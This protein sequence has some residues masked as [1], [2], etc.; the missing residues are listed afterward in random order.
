MFGHIAQMP[1]ILRLAGFHDAV[2][3]R[4]VPSQVTKNA[5]VWEAPDGSSV[6]AE[7]LPVGYGNG[8]ALPDDAKAL[9]RRTARQRGRGGRLPHRRPAVHER[10]GPPDAP[11]LARPGRGRGQRPAGRVRLRGDLAPPLPGRRRP[12]RAST[13]VQGELRSGFRANMLMGV[14]SN[15]VD[16]KRQGALAERELE[17]RAEPLAALFQA[18]A[19]YPERLL[20]LAWLEMVRNSAHDSICACSVDDVV[21]AVLHRYAEARAIAAGLA[22]RAVKAFARSLAEP[23]PTRAQP[24]A[25]GPLRRRRAGRPR[26]RPGPG[27]RAGAL[28]AVRAARIDGARRRHGAHGAGHAAGTARSTTTPGSTTCGSRTPTRASTSRSPSG[29][30]RSPTSPSPRP[31]RTSTPG[32]GPGPT[33]WS[34]WPWTSRRRG[35]SSPA[36]AR[37]RGTAGRPSSRRRWPTPSRSTEA[38]GVGRVCQRAGARSTID[39]RQ[40]D[41]RPRRHARLR[42]AGRRRRPRRLV[43]LLAAPAGL[44]RRHAASRHRPGRRAGPGAG[45]GAHHQHLRLARPRRRL[46][47]GAG[48]RAPGRRR[49]RRGAAGGRATWCG[50]RPRSSTR[51]ATTA[52]ASTCRSPSRRSHSHAESAFTVVTRGLTAEGRPDEFGLPTAPVQPLRHGRAPD[53]GP[54]GRVRVRAVDVEGDAARTMALTVLRSTGMLSRL[55][56]AYR[57]FPAGPL[58]PVEGLQMRGKRVELRYALAL[59]CDD[60]YAAGRRRPAPARDRPEPGRRPAARLGQ[61]AGGARRRGQRA[62]PGGRRARGARLQPDGPAR[63]WSRSPVA[64]GWLVDLRGYPQE[65]FEGS[66]ELRPFGIATARLRDD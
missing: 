30:R 54:R 4:G 41:L 12:P 6:R 61:R 43:Q 24:V 10:V 35:R 57:P 33:P 53:R 50:S 39:P 20:E 37:C 63:R 8:A 52:C 16:V 32:S 36:P 27:R 29:P 25:A 40:R 38:D 55:G 31:S 47:A 26:R 46:V 28:R 45:P 58:T 23:G 9:V 64:P 51:A 65:P 62:P 1:Q 22:D 19:D 5:F 3:W 14:T 48:G 59:D 44:V 56:M 17:R 60:P 66:F 2:V 15:R 21:D 7:Y 11:A 49:H 34:A 42:P 18:P 13:R